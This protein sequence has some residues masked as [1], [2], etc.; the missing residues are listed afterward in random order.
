M[1]KSKIIQTNQKIKKAMTTGYANI[2]KAVVSVYTKIEDRF[3]DHYLTKEGET[4][5]QAKQR[6]ANN[7]KII[8]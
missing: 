1:A 6:L 7:K 8:G 3:V 2:E 4:V 5:A